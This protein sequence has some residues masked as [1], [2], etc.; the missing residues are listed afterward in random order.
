[1]ITYSA[2]ISCKNKKAE[3]KHAIVHVYQICFSI[4]VLDNYVYSSI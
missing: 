2:Y 4:S 3:W 1:M